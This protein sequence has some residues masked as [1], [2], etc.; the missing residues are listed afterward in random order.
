MGI[1]EELKLKRVGGW[2]GNHIISNISCGCLLG[3]EQTSLAS[4]SRDD[5]R[6]F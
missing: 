3:K 4:N 5:Y 6:A 2:E 1:W